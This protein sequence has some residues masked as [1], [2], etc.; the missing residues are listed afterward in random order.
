LIGAEDAE[1]IGIVSR[2]YQHVDA[3]LYVT[4]IPVAETIKYACNSFQPSK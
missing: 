4:A 1:T 3:P 2:L